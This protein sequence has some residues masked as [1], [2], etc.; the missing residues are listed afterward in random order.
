MVR[1][2]RD[3]DKCSH[4]NKKNEKFNT[5]TCDRQVTYT[6]A[7]VHRTTTDDRDK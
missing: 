1:K 7:P 2:E 3:K 5:G 6:H 4:V